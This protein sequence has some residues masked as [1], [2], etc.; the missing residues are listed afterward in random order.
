[1][2]DIYK[3]GGFQIQGST[4]IPLCKYLDIYGSLGYREVC[5]KALSSCEKT[6]LRVIPIDIG[7]KPIGN[8]C[9]YLYYSFAIGPR[10]FIFQQKNCSAYVDRKVDNTGIGFFANTGLNVLIKDS[11]LFAIFGEYSYEKQ[12]IHPCKP[13]VYSNGRVQMGGFA[14]GIGLG[15]AF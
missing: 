12:K 1:M 8:F 10:L 2:S 6:T 9:D 3:K 7:L 15:Y 5:G 11:L 4:S 13:Y 14:I